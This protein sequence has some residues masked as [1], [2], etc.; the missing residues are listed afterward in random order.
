MALTPERI[1][2]L[3]TAEELEEGYYLLIDS[4]T[5]GTRKIAVENFIPPKLDLYRW[6]FTKSL[7]DEVQGKTA[8]ISGNAT[9]G[10][11]GVVISAK[12]GFL[13]FLGS[14][15]VTADGKVIEIDLSLNIASIYAQGSWIILGDSSNNDG[16]YFQQATNVWKMYYSRAQHNSSISWS[17]ESNYNILANGG[18]LKFEVANQKMNVYLNDELVQQFDNFTTVNLYGIIGKAYGQKSAFTM[19]IR[20]I[21]IYENEEV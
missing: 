18:I 14:D 15:E 20:S 5:L 17:E 3:P 6:D 8:T 2:A 10:N 12:D 11:D 16:Y 19:T 7:V 21:R 9:Q 4:P 1:T 13:N